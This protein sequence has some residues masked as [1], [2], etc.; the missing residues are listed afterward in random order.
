MGSLNKQWL[1]MLMLFGISLNI[2]SQNPTSSDKA[3]QLI[4][5][6]SS[7]LQISEGDLND[8]YVANAYYD[9]KTGLYMVYAQQTYKGAGIYNAIQTMAFKNNKLVAKSGS[10]L[11]KPAIKANQ[12]DGK[13]AISAADALRSA[14]KHLQVALP[15]SFSPQGILKNGHAMNFG[16]LNVAFN[17]I[18][19]ELMWYP[20]ASGQLRL[21]WQVEL[22]P[23]TSSDNWLVRIDAATGEYFGKVNLT[24]SCQFGNVENGCNTDIDAATSSALNFDGQPEPPPTNSA[25]FNVIPYPFESPSHHGDSLTIVTNPWD[26]A[27]PGNNA[28]TLQWNSTS[29][30]DYNISRGNNVWAAEDSDGGNGT[31]KADTS[32]TAFPNLTFT[33]PFDFNTSTTTGNNQKAAITNLFYWNNIVHDLSYQY[34]FTEPA[35]NFQADNLGR[36]GIGADYVIA[37]AQD[38]GGSNNANFSTSGDGNRPRMQMYLWGSDATKM[39]HVLAPVGLAGFKK[40]AESAFSN[41]NKLSTHPNGVEGE[42][43]YYNDESGGG[44]GACVAPSNNLTG[45]IALIAAS[46]C[47]YIVKV[48]NAQNAG[49]IAAI[50]IATG[51]NPTAMNGTDN[52]I[53]IPAIMI[54]AADGQAMAAQLALSTVNVKLGAPQRIDGDLDNGVVIHEYT[55]GISTRLTGGPASAGCLGNAEQMGEGW[56]DFFALMATTNWATSSLND[57]LKLRPMG[58]YAYGQTLE[59]DGI[60]TYPYSIDMSI[61]PWTYAGVSSTGGEP[62]NVGEIWCTVLWDMTWDLIKQKGITPNLFDASATGGNNVAMQLVTEGMKLQPCSPGFIDGRD[63]ILKADSLLYGGEHTCAIWKAFARRGLGYNAKQGSSDSYSDQTVNFDNPTGF[64]LIKTSDRD[65]VKE[66]EIITYSIKATCKCGDLQNVKIVDTLSNQLTYISGGTYNDATR[67]VSIVVP[68]L[69]AGVTQ[70]LIVTASVNN[71]TYFAPVEHVADNADALAIPAI[72]TNNGWASSTTQ[73]HSGGRAYYSKN[74]VTSVVQSLTTTEGYPLTGLS[75]LSFWHYYNTEPGWDGG[76]VEISLNGGAWKDLGAYMKTNGYNS[77]IAS[78]AANTIAGRDAFTGFSNGFVNTVIDLGLFA[79]QTARFRFYFDQDDNTAADGWYVDDIMLKSEAGV[80]NFVE[81]YNANGTL[82]GVNWANTYIEDVALPLKWLSFAATKTGSTAL[83]QWET[84][85]EENTALYNVQKSND[86]SHFE[87]IGQLK[88]SATAGKHQYQ[89]KDLRPFTGINYYRL[90]QA[91]KDGKSSFSAT[92]T[93]YFGKAGFTIAPNPAKNYIYVNVPSD[94][95]GKATMTLID[96]TGR[97]LKEYALANESNLLQLPAALPA[98]VYNTRIA[99][100][101]TVYN[102]KLAIQ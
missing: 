15:A 53:T 67:E 39:C 96:A 32:T 6:N 45:K 57:T 47:T 21:G 28:T 17:E 43:V 73:S 7:S 85:S 16:T 14:A 5:Q 30:I 31:G 69:S 102:Q 33:R 68:N 41:A 86:G 80:I 20:Q 93:L 19:T 25:S 13:S 10:R 35:G 12:M 59:G 79:G 77:N 34:G 1:L 52:T 44:H 4:R 76:V 63:A 71:G 75:S 58:T 89:F 97:I 91:D 40:G 62:H 50:V 11:A 37:D 101:G 27:G 2:Y 74:Q 98:G 72:Y 18:T 64:S 54:S 22:A 9:E 81:A 26:L 78:N 8:M 60:R 46:G 82:A 99:Y 24:I 23:T 38:G 95:A 56:S 48:K 83:L 94:A 84:I 65:T 100:A 3:L 90:Q 49:A 87:D 66:G 36:G 55:H 61:N 92:K 70:E 29:A 88:A 51:A 42:V